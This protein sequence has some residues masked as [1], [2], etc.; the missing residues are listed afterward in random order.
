MLIKLLMVL[1]QD[2][3][4]TVSKVKIYWGVHVLQLLNAVLDHLGICS[5]K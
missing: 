3:N 5:V 1:W 4:I 2:Y